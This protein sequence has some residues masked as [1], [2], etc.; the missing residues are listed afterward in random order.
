MTDSKPPEQRNDQDDQQSRP[1]PEERKAELS[2]PYPPNLRNEEEVWYERTRY[3]ILLFAG[4]IALFGLVLGL[5]LDW[6]IDP[7]TS[8]QKKDLVQALGLITAGVAGAVGIFFTWRGQRLAREAQESN[9]KN[10]LS[11]LKNAQEQLVLARRS[12]ED[13]QRNTQEQLKQAQ[14]ELDITRRGQITERFTQAINQLGAREGNVRLGG[15]Y[16]LERTAREDLDYHWPIME[17]LTAYVRQ[18]APRK[19]D[20]EP[21]SEEVLSPEHVVQA[22]L[23]VI[24]RRSAYH[25][26]S[27]IE[28][29]PIDLHGTDLRGANLYQASLG[30]SYLAGA[31]LAG[32]NLSLADLAGADLQRSDLSAA[33]L[34]RTNLQGASL[35]EANLQEALFRLTKLQ[36]ANMEGSNLQGAS[37]ELADLRRVALT[38]ADLSQ[39]NFQ[40]THLQGAQLR[41]ADLRGATGL[42]QEQLEQANGDG[43][44]QL[45]DHLWHPSSWA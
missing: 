23:T 9:Q 15:V 5:I 29:G 36:E 40:G 11:Q 43:S 26:T 32:A 12:Q 45:P 44:T 14:N 42:T 8:T 19:Q 39:A 20:E 37:F 7:Q 35:D 41:G 25:M 33:I 16:S 13:N 30:G 22:I 28:L 10:T 6:Y 3:Q 38:A 24:G 1:S 17:V 4:G 27:E 31:N 21:G 34:I 18:Q 2:E